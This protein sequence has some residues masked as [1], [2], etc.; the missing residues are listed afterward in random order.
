MSREQRPEAVMSNAESSPGRRRPEGRKPGTSAAQAHAAELGVSSYGTA[1][2][3]WPVRGGIRGPEGRGL[4]P[5][6]LLPRLGGAKDRDL[7][8]GVEVGQ[9]FRIGSG[10]L[11]QP[12]RAR[13]IEFCDSFS[14]TYV[15]LLR[16]SGVPGDS[17][18]VH[19][20]GRELRGGGF[21]RSQDDRGK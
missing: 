11:Q 18:T 15:C 8:F 1:A 16:N 2:V 10:I 14:G 4:P 6:G 19:Q 21:N 7:H 13:A 12:S 17:Q 3:P 9:A 20:D 5:P